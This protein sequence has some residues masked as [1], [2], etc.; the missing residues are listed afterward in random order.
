MRSKP[1]VS[2]E[3]PLAG[4]LLALFFSLP[5][6]LITKTPQHIIVSRVELPVFT[7]EAAGSMVENINPVRVDP[8]SY[9]TGR[10]KR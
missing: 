1:G 4:I 10:H 5:D 9:K 2:H 3:T 8:H 7:Y 6:G